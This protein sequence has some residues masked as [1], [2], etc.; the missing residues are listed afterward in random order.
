M[1]NLSLKSSVLI[2]VAGLIS[3]SGN[4]NAQKVNSLY[5]LENT[6]INVRMNPAMSPKYSGF[7]IGMS[8]MSLYLQSDLA[9]DDIFYPGSDGELYTILHPDADKSSF[10]S[11]LKDVS[12]FNFGIGLE[13]FSLGFRIKKDTYLSIHSG[14][15]MDM[16]LG[17]PKDFF[18]FFMLGM[19]NDANSTLFDMT[20]LKLEAML[21]SKTGASFSTNIGNHIKIG[22]GINY[23]Q[24]Y[25]NASM[26]FDQFTINASETKWDVSSKGYL[27]VAGPE[28]FK[29]AYSED[30]YL[31][32]LDGDYE[33]GSTGDYSSTF[34]S[35]SKVGTGL[36]IDLGMTYKLLDFL[37]LSA[38]I[39][40][41]GSIKWNKDYIQKA[42]SNSNFSYEG[43]DIDNL[44]NNEENS[45]NDE[46]S[47]KI[48]D[49]IRFEKVTDVESYKSKLTTKLNI[50][51]ELGILKNHI[52][53]GVLSQTG[54]TPNGKYNDLMISANLK[55][56][57][58]IQTALTY[59]L[60]HGE[61]SSFGAALNVKLLFFNVFLAAD[62]IP[63]QYTTQMLPVSNSYYNFQ[64]GMNFMF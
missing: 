15:N 6:P 12:S 2:L 34:N 17:L 48:Q 38:S 30:G 53:F 14:I 26:G 42:S 57:S 16:G 43:S 4:V 39:T 62:Y 46:M 19:D 64:G 49:I 51:A 35:M 5:F 10:V 23:L 18:K 60:L 41:L 37:T 7:G 13:L 50:A 24:G 28:D 22:V 31:S 20:N 27:K 29:L 11:S 56:G 55:P 54:Y 8:S 33:I 58:V 63:L 1:N 61:A 9:V 44:T 47:E 40:D 32:G 21:Y 52:T 25:M 45:N 3:V 36:S 59:S